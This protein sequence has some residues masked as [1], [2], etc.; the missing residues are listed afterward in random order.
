MIDRPSA[1]RAENHLTPLRYNPRMRTLLVL[2]VLLLL[3]SP[4]VYADGP[5]VGATAPALPEAEWLVP[6]EAATLAGHAGRV[7]L[8]SFWH[9][10]DAARANSW[11]DVWQETHW[12]KG[13]RV[14]LLARVDSEPLQ[15][16]VAQQAF[17]YPVASVASL[18]DYE[19][20]AKAG[21]TVLVGADGTVAWRGPLEELDGTLVAKLLRQVKLSKEPPTPET[22]EALN[23]LAQRSAEIGAPALA[24]D[25]YDHV[26][27]RCK[28]T[29]DADAAAEAEKA[30]KKD[31][32]TKKAFAA[33]KAFFNVASAWMRVGTSE[34]K[35]KDLAKKLDKFLEKHG[36]T[37]TGAQARLIL[38][39][40]RGDAAVAAMRAF[41]REQNVSTSGGSWRT[42]LKKPP[43]LEFT[44]GR[45][46]F[47]VLE[48]SEGPM[49]IRFLPDVA[50]M[51]VSSTIYLTELGFYDGLVF[52]RVIPG[53]MAQGG[54][55]IGKGT[56][57]PG[58]K[59]SGEF[60][61]S[62]R[63]DKPG[64]LS[65]ANAGPGTDGSQF[66]ILF[67]PARHLDGKH[68]IFGELVEGQG[69]LKKLE[70]QGSK[71]NGT[72]K[73]KMVIEKATIETE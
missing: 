44:K 57:N 9:D 4:T 7:V 38:G 14:L 29:P 16:R 69:T 45:S 18:G 17:A 49:R 51:H 19:A 12:K 35:Q 42:T 47:W 3:C 56:G 39:S 43:Q 27:K 31:S 70:A 41:I 1:K 25:V 2:S 60:D 8:V 24:V 5:T 52:H 48:T 46:Y 40:L 36:E 63:H 50:P 33:A 34:R 71:P 68:T 11:L 62:V 58:Y 55:P 21:E 23:A 61:S 67:K 73:K 20:A 13:L 54:C 28:K 65:M 15:T 64:L 37:R 53:F 22:L 6:P 32:R 26:Q 72:P 59:Y 66:F 10:A 30:L